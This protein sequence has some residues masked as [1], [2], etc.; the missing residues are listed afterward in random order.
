MP[1]PVQDVRLYVRNAAGG[2]DPHSIT[3]PPEGRFPQ[4]VRAD[5]GTLFALYFTPSEVVRFSGGV[6]EVVLESD[7]VAPFRAERERR[8]QLREGLEKKM[9]GLRGSQAGDE[10]D[11][12]DGG[13]AGPP[14]AAG[15]AQP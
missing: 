9:M 3:S 4:F 6:P 1:D 13:L 8:R 11:R 5:D 2:F 12:P 7:E 14:K 10:D 15:G